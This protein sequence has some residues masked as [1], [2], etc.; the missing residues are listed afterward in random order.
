MSNLDPR[1]IPIAPVAGL[2]ATKL[3]L[4]S[5][6]SILRMW[7]NNCELVAHYFDRGLETFRPTPEMER[8]AERKAA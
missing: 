5:Q 3:L 1:R 2:N 4:Q 8:E 7:A 6:A